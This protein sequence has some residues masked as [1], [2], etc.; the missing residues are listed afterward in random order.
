MHRMPRF[1]APPLPSSSASVDIAEPYHPWA[2]LLVQLALFGATGV[3]VAFL[4]PAP[5][6]AALQTS[7]TVRY[8]V[9]GGI[10]LGLLGMFAGAH[11][12]P[13]LVLAHLLFTGA[14][15]T[16]CAWGA[17]Q[18]CC[19]PLVRTV[20]YDG[21]TSPLRLGYR[22]EWRDASP[23]ACD[24]ASAI[25]RASVGAAAGVLVLSGVVL[26]CAT[27]PLSTALATG[28]VLAA[29]ATV[30]LNLDA[31]DWRPLFTL[32]SVLFLIG[33][34]GVGLTCLTAPTPSKAL[35]Q[36]WLL[37]PQTV[38]ALA[39]LLLWADPRQEEAPPLNAP[40]FFAPYAFI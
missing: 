3:G 29:L 33:Y 6:L 17:A 7:L 11:S 10:G 36:V 27:R 26:L 31:W 9:L 2:P 4:T 21:A 25:G 12:P 28:V 32:L 39:Q 20:W 35:A 8:A 14:T 18:A 34:L 16:L 38:C 15:C 5:T 19:A 13:L 30:V 24:D 23:S 1:G 40:L 22:P 37:L